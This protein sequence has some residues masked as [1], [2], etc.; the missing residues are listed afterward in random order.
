MTKNDAVLAIFNSGWFS[1][2][3][4]IVG[5]FGI[6]LS[7]IFYRRGR[8]K[9]E[10]R[11]FLSEVEVIGLTSTEYSDGLEVQFEG[12]P[13]PQLTS[14]TYAI[15]NAG[16]TTIHGRDIVEKEPI[17]LELKGAGRFLRANID[18]STR[19]VNS[20]FVKIDGKSVILGFDY[21]DAGDGFRINIL[22]SGKTNSLFSLGAI[23]GV[24]LGL[25][26]HNPSKG[27]MIGLK[28]SIAIMVVL[29]VG[30]FASMISVLAWEAWTAPLEKGWRAIALI[31]A[32]ALLVYVTIPKKNNGE[33][34]KETI[35]GMPD[36]LSE[37]AKFYVWPSTS[38]PGGVDQYGSE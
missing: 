34:K 35:K 7:Y 38:S 4:L 20:A 30:M 33:V 17:R 19:E 29:M 1:L 5:A 14:A 9:T 36:A 23:K 15:W 24:P 8:H 25:I 37:G 18:A 3:G 11:D 12:C 10:L 6:L 2:L 26:R 13:I 22:H 27:L 16:T 31:G 21:L 32:I 28:I